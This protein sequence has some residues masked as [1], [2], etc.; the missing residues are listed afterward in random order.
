MQQATRVPQGKDVESM[1]TGGQPKKW[2]VK[3][4]AAIAL[5]NR[6]ATLRDV[7]QIIA[8]KQPNRVLK[9]PD[10]MQLGP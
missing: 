6:A 5:R 1:A 9:S 2:I 10:L 4:Q 3:R 7:P 8:T